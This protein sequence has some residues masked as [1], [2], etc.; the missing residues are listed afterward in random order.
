MKAPCQQQQE[1]QGGLVDLGMWGCFCLLRPSAE[2]QDGAILLLPSRAN[3]CLEVRVT[4]CFT[5]R[6]CLQTQRAGSSFAHG[7]ISPV[8]GQEDVEL[9]TLG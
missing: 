5:A 6:G 7:F 9:L 3:H 4:H 1:E 2:L 8:P